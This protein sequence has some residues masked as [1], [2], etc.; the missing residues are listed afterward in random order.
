MLSVSRLSYALAKEHAFPSPVGLVSRRYNTPWFGLVAQGVL[1]V[2]AST[3]WTSQGCS[4]RQ[5]S[6]W[7]CAMRRQAWRLCSLCDNLLR[8]R[9]GCPDCEFGWLEGL[10]A[11]STCPLRRLCS[12]RN[13]RRGRHRGRLALLPCRPPTPKT[14]AETNGSQEPPSLRRLNGLAKQLT[15]M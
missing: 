15:G 9:C 3:V 6:S 12:P 11:A 1:A 4:G 5:C 14:L 10:P 8:N 7:G 2:V 13:A